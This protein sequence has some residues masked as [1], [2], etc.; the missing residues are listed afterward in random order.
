MRCEH[1]PEPER[2]GFAFAIGYGDG[3]KAA[4]KHARGL[5]GTAYRS[6]RYIINCD[7]VSYRSGWYE[8]WEKEI[9]DWDVVRE[10]A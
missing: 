2:C 10:E 5:R 9:A 8:G 7:P 4:R 3:K 6:P 1:Q